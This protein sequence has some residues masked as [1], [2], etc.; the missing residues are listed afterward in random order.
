MKK[1]LTEI[2]IGADRLISDI[3]I[4]VEVALLKHRAASS[5]VKGRQTESQE[6]IQQAIVKEISLA[7]SR[8]IEQKQ[9]GINHGKNLQLFFFEANGQHWRDLPTENLEQGLMGVYEKCI[10]HGIELIPDLCEEAD[11]P[12]HIICEFKYSLEA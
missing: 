2:F 6:L 5:A 4:N 9:N 12:A 10:A 8:I 11:G 7:A 3:Q 1:A